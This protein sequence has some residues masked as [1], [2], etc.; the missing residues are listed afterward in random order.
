MGAFQGGSSFRLYHL[1]EP[2]PLQRGPWREAVA[3]KIREHAFAGIDPEGEEDRA[4]GWCSA[5]F[6]LDVELDESM[7]LYGE[8]LVLALRVDTIAVPGPL[9]KIYAESEARRVLAETKATSLNRYQKAEI[10]E[11]VKAD[12]KRRALPSIKTFDFVW[13]LDVGVVRFFSG[14]EKL[15]LEFMELFE[16]TFERSLVPDAAYTAATRAVP[17]LP[18]ALLPRLDVI[19]PGPLVDPDTMVR[20]MKEV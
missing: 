13:S 8:Y 18:E 17:A 2:L 11:R 19:E 10:K 1:A 6:P 5:H 15:N 4:V 3:A 7:Y 16:L 9:L 14:N 20:A 12:L